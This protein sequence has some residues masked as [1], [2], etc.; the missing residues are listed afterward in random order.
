M[1]SSGYVAIAGRNR[2]TVRMM[3]GHTRMLVTLFSGALFLGSPLLA[4]EVA[5]P[6][7][8]LL[9]QRVFVRKGCVNCHAIFGQ[10]GHVGRD[11]GKTQAQ[12]GPAGIVA[13]MW[14][15]SPEM[16]QVM[17]RPQEMPMFT[18][19]EMADLIAFLYFLSYL[20][21]PGVPQRGRAVLEQ[22][23]CLSCHSIG[24]QGGAIG[25]PLDKVGRFANPLSL[26]Q[27]MWNHGTGMTATMAARGVARPTFE[28][29][30]LVDLFAYLSQVGPREA[31]VRTYL[32]PGRPSIGA[33]LFQQKGCINCTASRTKAGRSARILRES[34]FMWASPA[35]PRTSGITRRRSG[36]R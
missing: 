35:L 34:A 36:R 28:G 12:R 27:S 14:N 24:G 16:S 18:E 15:H 13:M 20:D 11:L 3:S 29:S 1:S 31:D 6:N 9:G 5:L 19:R 21:E 26:A 2:T 23:R 17:Q 4:Q 7:D 8:P 22:K 30:E 25:S 10:G 32:I 33:R